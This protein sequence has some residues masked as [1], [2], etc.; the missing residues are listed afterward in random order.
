MGKMTWQDLKSNLKSH[1]LDSST[2]ESER[3]SLLSIFEYAEN[4]GISPELVQ[5]KRLSNLRTIIGPAKSAIL[6]DDPD[7][8]Q[9][10]F[11]DAGKMTNVE[12]RLKLNPRKLAPIQYFEHAGGSFEARYEL[13]VTKAQLDRIRKS[14]RANFI[15]IRKEVD[16]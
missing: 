5:I 8:L 4:K 11:Q 7:Y 14:T 15:F 1:D 3:R 10:L 2:W 13:R 12:L 6:E 9:E 16:T